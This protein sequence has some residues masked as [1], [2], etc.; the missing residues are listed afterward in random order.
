LKKRVK[1]YDGKKGTSK[2][3]LKQSCGFCGAH[4]RS[5]KQRT[6]HTNDCKDHA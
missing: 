2:V 5:Q 1:V 4:M 3:R 6:N